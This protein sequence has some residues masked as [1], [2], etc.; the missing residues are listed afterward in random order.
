MTNNKIKPEI[1]AGIYNASKHT[2]PDKVINIVCSVFEVEREDLIS[3]KRIQPIPDAR[4]VV[5]VLARRYNEKLTTTALGSIMGKDHSTVLAG[6]KKA[7]DLY[8][9]DFQFR[10]KMDECERIVRGGRPVGGHDKENYIECIGNLYK[11]AI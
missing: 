8:Q 10:K 7:N 6:C 3:G 11:K 2:D 4:K 9:F 5:F 1:F